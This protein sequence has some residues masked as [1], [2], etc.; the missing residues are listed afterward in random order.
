MQRGGRVTVAQDGCELTPVE[1]LGRCA[2]QRSRVE[3]CGEPLQ[4]VAR[5]NLRLAPLVDVVPNASAQD[6]P[7]LGTFGL[8]RIEARP[9][10]GLERQA[11]LKP[12]DR[13]G[14]EL[15]GGLKRPLPL[16]ID[17]VALEANRTGLRARGPIPTRQARELGAA[18][19]TQPP[20]ASAFQLPAFER[21]P[22]TVNRLIDRARHE[23]PTHPPQTCFTEECSGRP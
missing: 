4:R 14:V 15:P 16:E 20:R 19:R 12:F 13:R 8:E 22:F 11:I 2:C 3:T 9:I 7:R 17:A 23:H 21:N 1:Q 5:S 10:D 18:G 6:L